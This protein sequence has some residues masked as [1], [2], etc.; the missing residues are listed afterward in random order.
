MPVVVVVVAV[1]TAAA[2]GLP[3]ST[4]WLTSNVYGNDKLCWL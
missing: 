4:S 2:I 1:G 3:P